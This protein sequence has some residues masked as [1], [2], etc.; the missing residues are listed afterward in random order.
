[1]VGNRARPGGETHYHSQVATGLPAH[2]EEE[3][4]ICWTSIRAGERLLRPYVALARSPSY[5]D[6]HSVAVLEEYVLRTMQFVHKISLLLR[7]WATDY[8]F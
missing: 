8:T 1:M 6:Q 2:P 3:A 5:I 4:S 7:D